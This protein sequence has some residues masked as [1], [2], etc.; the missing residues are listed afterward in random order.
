M[1]FSIGRPF[2]NGENKDND[3]FCPF[4]FIYRFAMIG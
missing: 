3:K 2:G 4:S 1:I